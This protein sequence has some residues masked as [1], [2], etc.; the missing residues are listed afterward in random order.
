MLVV[1]VFLVRTGGAA[2]QS[3]QTGSPGS[4]AL[5][6]SLRSMMSL[7]KMKELGDDDSPVGNL[8]PYSLHAAG[9]AMQP[10][11]ACLTFRFWPGPVP[12]SAGARP[13]RR[14]GRHRHLGLGGLTR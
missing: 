6:R 3:D 4:Q 1:L 12:G 5:N 2:A 9:C 8:P 11:P 14:S 10:A 7:L 13:S